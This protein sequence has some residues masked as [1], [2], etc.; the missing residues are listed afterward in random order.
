[1]DLIDLIAINSL[2]KKLIYKWP[3]V[4]GSRLVYKILQEKY[5]QLIVQLFI[6]TFP[7]PPFPNRHFNSM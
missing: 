7:N 3:Y 6:F 2:F 4:S 5:N 1:M